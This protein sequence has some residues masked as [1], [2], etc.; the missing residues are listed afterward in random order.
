MRESIK[1]K[2]AM[3]GAGCT[4]FGERWE[5]GI[6]DLIKEAAVAACQDA[7]V[8]IKDIQAMWVGTFR[9]SQQNAAAGSTGMIVSAALQTQ[10]I[11]ITRVE[12]AC[13]SGIESMRGATYG[14]ASKAYDLTMAIGVEKLKDTG[15][16]GLGTMYPGKW[17]PVYGAFGSGPGRYAMN[18]TAYFAKYGLTMEEGKRML[19]E[20]SV[21][22]HYYGAR[23]PRAHLRREVTVEAAMNAPMIAWPLGL[24]DCCGVTDGAAACILC[25]AEEAKRYRDDYV[26]IKGF[27][28]ATSPGW[29]KERDDYD[30][31]YWDATQ[32][33]AKQAYAEAGI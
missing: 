13:G 22:S 27:G 17:E 28:I 21:K 12:N 9:G 11:P 10:Y 26:T 19:A 14:I 25:P 31:T 33:A 1:D 16:A 3:V 8:E 20:I 32:A 6:D 30:F 23:N 4:K 2:V 24:Y 18:A 15:F 7:G 5:A 29:G